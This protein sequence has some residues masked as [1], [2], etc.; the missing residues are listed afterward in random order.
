MKEHYQQFGYKKIIMM[1]STLCVLLFLPVT[2]HA[3][4]STV[5]LYSSRISLTKPSFSTFPHH[6]VTTTSPHNAT[7]YYG[8]ADGRA[9]SEWMRPSERA[10]Q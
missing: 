7:Q 2:V 6:N 1:R 5:L 3:F 9:F 10:S 8:I 4:L